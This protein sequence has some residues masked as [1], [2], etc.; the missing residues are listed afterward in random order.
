MPRA[1]IIGSGPNG[2][3]A[4]VTLARAGVEV[5]VYE[6]LDTIGGACSTAEITLPGFRHDLGASIFPMGVA[7]P[8]FNSLPLEQF[9]LRWVQ[10]DAAMAHPLDD[11]TAVIL[12]HDPAATAANLD[13]ADSAAYARLMQPFIRQWPEL[14]SEAFGPLLHVPKHPLLL[15]RFGTDGALPVSVLAR[16]R[17]R[18]ARARALLAGNASHAVLPLSH[19][20]TSAI[21]LVFG[22]A[23]HTTG[24]PAAAG[25][26]QSIS[27]ALAAYLESLGG[28]IVTGHRVGSLAELNGNFDLVLCDV[29]PRQLVELAGDLLPAAHIHQLK[30]FRPGPGAFKIDWA[31]SESIPWKAR[32]CLRAATV[33]VGGTLEEITAAESAPWKGRASQQPFVLVTQPSL[34]DPTRAPEGRHVAWGYCHVPNGFDEDMQDAIESQIE[35]FAPGFRD[36]ILARRISTP[37]QLEAWNPNLI[38]GDVSGGAI[39]PSQLLFRP[40]I[41]QYRTPLKGLYLCSASTPPGGGVH[42]MCGYYAAK[43]ALQHISPSL[44]PGH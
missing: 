38:G 26:A 32:E 20:F 35:R 6:A 21:A 30:R 15:A 31:L 1:A 13:P 23:A 36:C 44:T 24:W 16:S 27:I 11:G 22:A 4:A 39:T 10:P 41:W 18:G 34:F 17:F 2:L 25:G 7:S 9:G 43:T 12:E 40:T 14:F 3:S 42:G 5:T 29:A 28:K 8:F 19:P 37:A 33:H